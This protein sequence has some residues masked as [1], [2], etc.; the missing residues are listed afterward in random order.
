MKHIFILNPQAGYYDQ[1]QSLEENFRPSKEDE[2]SDR[3]CYISK[4]PMAAK[5]YADEICKRYPD[6]ELRFY[7]CG[8]DGTLN[9]VLNGIM[10]HPNALLTSY[11]S[12][13]GNDFIRTFGT[14]NDFCNLQRLL[15]GKA[16]STDLMKVTIGKG[17]NQ[18]VRYAL[19]VVD[20]G[21]D[22]IIAQK[23]QRIKRNRILGGY[24]SYKSALWMSVLAK[25]KH[26]CSISMNGEIIP[27]RRLMVC[28]LS[29]GRYFGGG[30]QCSPNSETND[31]ILE[32]NII[33]PMS[34]IVML[35]NLK[36][37]RTGRHL[38]TPFRDR[39]MI[40]RSGQIFEFSG[41]RALHMTIDGEVIKAKR[42]RVEVIPNAIQFIMPSG[43]SNRL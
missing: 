12:G 11:P 4:H 7:A 32:L 15:D 37:Y 33:R 3:I 5:E 2:A 19:N 36:M 27:L 6:E 24:K 42:I 13:I 40:C 43:L 20:M 25:R 31:G 1:T 39:Y 14:R 34:P 10:N 8:G 26:R 17:K 38:E 28:T 23:M 18:K 9:E 41:S 35:R 30:F 22:A 16:E 29:N 21:F